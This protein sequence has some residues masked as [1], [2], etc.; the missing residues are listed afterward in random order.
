M[1]FTA[2]ITLVA[3]CLDQEVLDYETKKLQS[4]VKEKSLV[5][6]GRGAFADGIS[7]GIV[8]SMVELTDAPKAT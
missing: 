5:I 1:A 8:K 3:C 6:S 4:Y 7:H 2:E